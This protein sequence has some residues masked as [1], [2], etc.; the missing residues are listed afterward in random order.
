MASA[1]AVCDDPRA[2]HW[3]Q[4]MVAE[5]DK[6]LPLGW[7]PGANF[8]LTP[9][10]GDDHQF[11]TEPFEGNPN[12]PLPQTFITWDVY[13]VHRITG[14]FITEDWTTVQFCPWPTDY[15]N[16]KVWVRVR[17]LNTWWAE[18]VNPGN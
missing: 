6:M 15:P 9:I 14:I 1:S 11:Y 2:K 16:S 12:K 17:H 13:A 7:G 10:D 5:R 8:R 18:I 3:S 4:R